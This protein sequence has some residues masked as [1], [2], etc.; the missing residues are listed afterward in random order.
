MIKEKEVAVSE[1]EVAVSEEEVVLSD[2][3]RDELVMNF[4]ACGDF[5]NTVTNNRTYNAAMEV[6]TAS[7]E[8]LHK[9]YVDSYD[10]DKNAATSTLKIYLHN[11]RIVPLTNYGLTSEVI[12]NLIK[13]K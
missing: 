7:F 8:Q 2:P 1:E 3:V 4:I 9:Y 11:M 13:G 10:G 6:V 12:N 5:M